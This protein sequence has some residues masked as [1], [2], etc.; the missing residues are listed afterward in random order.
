MLEL[1]L[2]TIN[3]VAL[4]PATSFEVGTS[5]HASLGVTDDQYGSIQVGTRDIRYNP[6][7]TDPPHSI[8]GMHVYVFYMWKLAAW[9]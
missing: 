4:P 5:V 6:S 3:V 1:I 2:V 9:L 8:R 7:L